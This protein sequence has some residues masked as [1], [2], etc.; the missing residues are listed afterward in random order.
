MFPDIIV[1]WMECGKI[2]PRLYRYHHHECFDLI[3]YLYVTTVITNSVLTNSI[4][5]CHNNHRR[6]MYFDTI[7]CSNISY[8]TMIMIIGHHRN[9]LLPRWFS[10]GVSR[11]GWWFPILIWLTLCVFWYIY[12]DLSGS[13]FLS[14]EEIANVKK[15]HPPTIKKH[16]FDWTCWTPTFGK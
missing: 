5:R 10:K 2:R 3:L 6:V 1:S 11:Y 9:E 4:D 16:H 13:F 7:T 12:F 14:W 8:R 15:N